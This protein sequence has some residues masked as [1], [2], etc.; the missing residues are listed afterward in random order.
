M[1]NDR[2][3]PS[4]GPA[5]VSPFDDEDADAIVVSSDKRQFRIYK[6]ILSKAS[7]VFRDMWS[8]PQAGQT[9]QSADNPLE[10]IDGLPVVHCSED[11]RTLELLFTLCYP[12]EHPALDSLD[13]VSSVLEACGKYFMDAIAPIVRKA[14]PAAASRDPLRAFAIACTKR[15]DEQ[16]RIAARLALSERIWPLEPP[17]HPSFNGVSADTIVRLESYQRKCSSAAVQ[18]IKNAQWA[19]RI[20]DT[21][22]CTRCGGNTIL[23]ATQSRQLTDWYTKYTQLSTK[24]L[25]LRPAG[26]TVKA[27]DFVNQSILAIYGTYPCDGNWHAMEKIQHVVALFADEVDKLISEVHTI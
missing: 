12:L 10:M 6:V 27:D 4:E 20:F 9:A 14:W 16:A 25:L 24:A 22:S 23:T 13:D 21:A 19:T 5:V 2:D 17:L 26:S 15:W 1:A 18:R 7:S 11:G 8:I 3:A